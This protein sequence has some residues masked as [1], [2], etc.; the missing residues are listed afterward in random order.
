LAEWTLQHSSEIND[1]PSYLLYARHLK[2]NFNG[3]KSDI[4]DRLSKTTNSSQSFAGPVT[5]NGVWTF[6]AT[7]LA[8]VINEKTAGTGVTLDQVLHKDG[9]IR[10]P[11]SAGYTP[12]TN[13]D[14]GYDSTSHTYDVYVNG[15]AKSL[16][17]TGSNID[18]LNDVVITTPSSGQGLTYDGSNWVNGVMGSL[19][20]L[21]SATA[22]NSASLDFTSDIDDTYDLYLL[23]GVGLV[24][25]S[26]AVA[27]W[28]RVTENGTDWKADAADYKYSGYV[29]GIAA[30]AGGSPGTAGQIELTHGATLSNSAANAFNFIAFICQPAST[31]SKK[32][33]NFLPQGYVTSGGD[34]YTMMRTGTYVGTNNAITGLRVLP[35]SG[36]WTSGSCYLY[37]V[38]K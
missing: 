22:S 31:T 18:D 38:K 30:G 14:F 15:A 3:L 1:G 13:G 36:N 27:A 8:D 28:L 6:E 9:T 2:D 29:Y 35:S 10:V 5:V 25:A 37:G 24:P 21:D 17:H 20:L 7:P 16:L 33:I 32:E 26:D 12:T 19:V 23:I 4:D 11:G 34:Y